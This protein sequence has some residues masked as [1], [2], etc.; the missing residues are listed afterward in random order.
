MQ[1]QIKQTNKKTGPLPSL[2]SALFP[3]VNC[4]PFSSFLFQVFEDQDVYNLEINH[5][6]HYVSFY[7]SLLAA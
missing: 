7:A 4:H 2:T 3:R 5:R 1:Y 6:Q